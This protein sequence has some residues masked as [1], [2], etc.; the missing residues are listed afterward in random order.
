MHQAGDCQKRHRQIRGALPGLPGGADGAHRDLD[1]GAQASKLPQAYLAQG[2]RLV[3]LASI[4]AAAA[5]CCCLLLL[6]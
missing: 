6:L 3:G 1:G 4:A 2:H 5:A